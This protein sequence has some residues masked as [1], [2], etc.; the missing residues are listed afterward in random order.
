MTALQRI[1]IAPLARPLPSAPRRP[2]ESYRRIEAT[3][4]VR[5]QLAM[6]GADASLPVDIAASLVSE[7]ALLLERLETSRRTRVRDVLDRAARSSRVTRALSSTSADYLR[8]LSCRSWRRQVAELDLPVRV[9][10]GLGEEPDRL[11]GR[12]D[13]LEDAIRWETAALLCGRTMGEWGSGVIR[14]GMR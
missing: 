6:A 3:L 4:P 14:G 10:A 13:L 1:P 5:R 12:C 9:V 2:G 11:L 8:A 7:A